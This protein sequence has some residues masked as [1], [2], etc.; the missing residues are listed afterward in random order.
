MQ[1][2][3]KLTPVAPRDLPTPYAG[4]PVALDRIGDG[5]GYQPKAE[6]VD[7]WSK[8]SKQQQ[9]QQI[10]PAILAAE[11]NGESGLKNYATKA[12][13]PTMKT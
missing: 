8:M 12:T 6:D 1:A 5:I 7:V 11:N 3:T 10:G 4:T 13:E 2:A 9:S